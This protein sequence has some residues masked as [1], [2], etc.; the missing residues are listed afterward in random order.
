[1][2]SVPAHGTVSTRKASIH[3]NVHASRDS[4]N[5][6]VN[7]PVEH[8]LWA[9][10]EPTQDIGVSNNQNNAAKFHA[11]PLLGVLA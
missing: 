2:F 10:N 6:T 9:I 7:P 11:L 4:G 3:T 5:A 8:V 1:V